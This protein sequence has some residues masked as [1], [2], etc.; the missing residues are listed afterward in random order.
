MLGMRGVRLGMMKPGLYTM[1]VRAI[2]EAACALK[3][4]G[5]DPRPEIMVPLVGI[6]EELRRARA[7]A[8][9]VV[10]EVM[11]ATGQRVKVAIGTMIEIPRA[12][13]VA[14]AI[15]EHADFFSFG[16]NDL[17]QLAFGFS[18]DDVAKILDVY[19]TGGLLPVDPFTT[20]DRAGVGSLM[21]LAVEKARAVRPRIK[22]GICG[23]HGGD[24]ESI[25]FCHELGLEYVSASP[26]RVPVAR[27][28]AA[29]AAL[30]G[31]DAASK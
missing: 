31:A 24:P 3:A 14:D 9:R 11:A 28:A 15:A 29:H 13:T 22:L 30:G 7:D 23:E 8:E 16:T 26:F 5:F 18:R 4:E 20:L 6:D 21:R 2:M 1:Q 19:I 12:C 25:R 17:T 27:L 10:K